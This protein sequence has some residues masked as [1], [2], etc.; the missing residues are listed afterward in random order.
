MQLKQDNLTF[1]KLGGSV[2]TAKSG[3]EAPDLAIIQQLA[4]ELSSAYKVLPNPQILLG[5]GSGSFGHHYAAQ[6][7]VHAGVQTAEE[8]RGFALTAGAASRLNQLVVDELL[9]VGLPALTFQPSASLQSGG[10]KITDWQTTTLRQALH[11][12]LLPVIHGDVAFDSAQGSS[13][14]STES[15]FTYLILKASFIPKQIILVG[16][17]AVYT[18]DPRLDQAAQRIPRIS[19]SNIATVLGQAGGSHAVDVTGGM[20]TKLATMWQ[21]VEA[22]PSLTVQLIGTKPGP[23]YQVLCGEGEEEGTIIAHE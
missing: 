18:A 9:K 10:G 4:Q 17:D 15:L 16:E 1:I 7:R 12:G 22:I 8:W 23:L 6:Y 11:Y 2:I 19:S 14:V 5:H 21:L 20:Q 3:K 13:I